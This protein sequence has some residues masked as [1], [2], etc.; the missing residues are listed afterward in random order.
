MRDSDGGVLASC[1]TSVV[2]DDACD[3]GDGAW[4]EREREEIER[5]DDEA[6]ELNGEGSGSGCSGDRK[7]RERREKIYES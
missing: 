6:E 3:G 5:D 2:C 1:G 4:F 7:K